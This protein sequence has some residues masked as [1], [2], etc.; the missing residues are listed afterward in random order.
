LQCIRVF[1]PISVDQTILETWTFRLRGAPEEIL[2]RSLL[3]NQTIFSPASIAGHDDNEAFCRMQ[4][5]LKSGGLEWVSLHRHM[6]TETRNTD[7]TNSAPG[8]S[9]ITYRHEYEAWLAYMKID[10]E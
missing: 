10:E 1:R 6:D 2:K 4:Q 9:D 8:T 7:G 5:G 3:Y